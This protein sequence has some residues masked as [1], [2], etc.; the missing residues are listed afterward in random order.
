MKNK[1]FKSV[2]IVG[3]ILITVVLLNGSGVLVKE[4]E[5]KKG[6]IAETSSDTAAKEIVKEKLSKENEELQKIK[7]LKVGKYE[8]DTTKHKPNDEILLKKEEKK[9][10]KEN[11]KYVLKDFYKYAT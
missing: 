7:I 1:V 4:K 2:L 10:I 8:I 6:T 5:V 9:K 3:L 11:G